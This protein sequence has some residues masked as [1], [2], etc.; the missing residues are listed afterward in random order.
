MSARRIEKAEGCLL[1][2]SSGNNSRQR[3]QPA[4]QR[5]ALKAELLPMRMALQQAIQHLV[6]HFAARV[7]RPELDLSPGGHDFERRAYRSHIPA[8][9]SLR[10]FV[11]G[12]Q[13]DAAIAVQLVQQ[14]T[15][16]LFE[17]D[18]GRQ[19]GY[20]DSARRGVAQLRH[21]TQASAI[22]P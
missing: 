11:A 4:V 15:E 7:Q 10:I 17:G 14:V 18:G 12:R 8:R 20:D 13:I 5:R 2:S 6:E 21:K 9:I 22:W 3:L 19:A 16:A 1:R